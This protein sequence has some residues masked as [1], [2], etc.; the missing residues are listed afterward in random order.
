M[1]AMR[2]GHLRGS[3]PSDVAVGLRVPSCLTGEG[4][5]TEGQS[6]W[7]RLCTFLCPLKRSRGEEAKG[8]L[9]PA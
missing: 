9:N 6:C 2:G 3:L 5:N 4:H 1:G 7:E 8:L